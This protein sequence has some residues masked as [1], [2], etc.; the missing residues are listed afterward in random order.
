MSARATLVALGALLFAVG[1]CMRSGGSPMG[2]PLR[3]MTQFDSEW[4][5]YQRLGSLKVL[6]VAGDLNGVYVSG[7]A[8]AY[9]IQEL[10]ND[11][12]LENCEERRADRRVE[13]ECRL[14]AIGDDRIQEARIE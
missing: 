14:Y 4:K 8:F 6:A 5:N 9:P 11:E 7:F 3:E 1:G 12:A 10:A 2:I 13:D